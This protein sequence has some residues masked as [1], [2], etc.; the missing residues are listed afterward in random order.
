MEIVL[1]WGEKKGEKLSD[2]A[3]GKF[4]YEIFLNKLFGVVVCE[5]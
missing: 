5:I 1:R 4:V 2:N 3:K